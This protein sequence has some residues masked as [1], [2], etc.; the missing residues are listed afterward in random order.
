MND[1]EKDSTRK[2]RI[3]EIKGKSTSEG[4]TPANEEEEVELK[5]D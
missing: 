4:Y 1:K 5:G 2:E 3:K